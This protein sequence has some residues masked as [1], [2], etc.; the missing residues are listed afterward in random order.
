MKLRLSHCYAQISYK[1]QLW[2]VN[3]ITAGGFDGHG[4]KNCKNGVET[5]GFSVYLRLY[6]GRCME[7]IPKAYAD[8]LQFSRRGDVSRAI[9]TKYMIHPFF[10]V[11]KRFS[12]K[13][14]KKTVG[15]APF[16]TRPAAPGR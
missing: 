14:A 7:A 9:F 2:Q 11:G 6:I 1:N 16:F 8:L 10:K 3:P 15:N 12:G 5:A 4:A 13:S